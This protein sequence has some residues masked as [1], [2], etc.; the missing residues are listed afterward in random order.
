V[1]APVLQNALEWPNQRIG[2]H[3][4]AAILALFGLAVIDANVA[5]ACSTALEPPFSVDPNKAGDTTPPSP[6]SDLS[7]TT[8][9]VNGTH[10][11]GDTCSSTSCGDDGRLTLTFT[12]PKDDQTAAEQLGYRVVW[13]DGSAPASLDA[14]KGTRSLPNTNQIDLELG[15]DGI[16]QLN[17]DLA[18]IAVD[19]AGN[20]SAMSKPIHVEYSGCT[21][22]FD[23]PG[24]IHASCAVTGRVSA[25]SNRSDRGWLLPLMAAGALGL[26]RRRTRRTA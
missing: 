9:R 26:A 1:L 20:E 3:C 4:G 7:A 23:T 17:G 12:A 18:L 11:H 14:Y 10:C 19:R 22:Y 5:Q 8:L 21:E 25:Q 24:C 16:E 13:L 2:L 15:F 6:F